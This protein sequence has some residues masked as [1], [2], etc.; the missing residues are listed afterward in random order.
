MNREDLKKL[1]KNDYVY[2]R[3][4][5]WDDEPFDEF[6]GFIV[7]KTKNGIYAYP[8]I[9]LTKDEWDTDNH[10]VGFDEII[11]KL[12]LETLLDQIEVKYPEILL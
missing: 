3:F 7:R 11:Q 9:C 12:E 10:Y 6:V 8:E 4:R 1:H 2:Y 5:K